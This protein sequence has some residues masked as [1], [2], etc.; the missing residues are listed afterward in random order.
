[1]RSETPYLPEEELDETS[2]V[3]YVHWIS[4]RLGLEVPLTCDSNGNM[5]TEQLAELTKQVIKVVRSV[6]VSTAENLTECVRSM[7]QENITGPRADNNEQLAFSERKEW[8]KMTKNE[9]G[10]VIGTVLSF[11]FLGD[12]HTGSGNGV[13]YKAFYEEIY[14]SLAH[15]D[16]TIDDTSESAYKAENMV[17]RQMHSMKLEALLGMLERGQSE[18]SQE[19]K[20]GTMVPEFQRSD[21][22]W[23]ATNWF[24]FIDSGL[25]DIPMPSIVLGKSKDTLE[26]PWQVIDGNQRL[27]TIWKIF[28]EDHDD[29]V[30]VT[31]PWRRENKMPAWILERLLEYEFNVEM[32]VADSD[33]DLAALYERYNASGRP[34]TQP[35]LRV[36]KHHE[37]SALHHLLLALSGGPTLKNRV[38]VRH[39]LGIAN[40]IDDRSDRASSL[41]RKIPGVSG[42]VT[43]DEKKQLRKVTEK[44]Y[45][46]WCRIVAYSTYRNVQGSDG[47]N[48]T[49]KQ[50][51]DKVFGVFRNGSKAIDI[52]DRLDYV[53]KEVATAY[54]DYAFLSLRA[55]RIKDQYDENGDPLIEYQEGKSVHG[56]A[57]QVQC[58]AF[59]DLSDDDISLLKRNPDTFQQTWFSF[60]KSY[61]VNARQNSKSIWEVQEYWK[62]CV[63]DLLQ[64]FKMGRLSNEDSEER[65]RLLAEVNRVLNMP[66]DQRHWVTDGWVEPQYSPEQIVF[67]NEQLE[68][69]R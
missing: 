37:V 4:H 41:R 10:M 43:P 48:P 28:N 39:R 66:E 45:D 52:V 23:K 68:S 54:G 18:N 44:V 64:A 12:P 32:I 60:A 63:A 22:Q 11:P 36:A 65:Q 33:K 47:P 27:S 19:S 57:T 15:A 42:T 9:L 69:L 29:H 21:Q 25:R 2:K 56:W 67:L 61:I 35:Q 14:S 26:Y 17:D 31:K 55:V 24:N 6:D 1:M 34:M 5:S 51:I 8:G 58:A 3:S 40:S 20:D 13:I 62:D 16:T 30:R 53:V 50:A 38:S 49:A 59:W 46:L 7:H